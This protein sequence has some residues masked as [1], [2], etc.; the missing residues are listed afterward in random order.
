MATTKT[1]VNPAWP[2]CYRC[3]NKAPVTVRV[4]F[5]DNN[6]H[7]RSGELCKACLAKS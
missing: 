5:E 3:G 7:V 2:T 6:G 4:T 1:P